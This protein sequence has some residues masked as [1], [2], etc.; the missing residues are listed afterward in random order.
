MY[1]LST[2]T[3]N[4]T[5]MEGGFRDIIA[6]Q[7]AHDFVLSVYSICEKFPSYERFGLWSQFTRAAVSI[8]AN[9]AEG[10]KK[11]SRA[12]KLRFLNISQSSLEECRYYIILSRDLQYI[13]KEDADLLNYKIDGASWYL[14]AYVNGIINNNGIKD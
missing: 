7:K 2:L 12:D 4:L 3:P 13:S 10:T 11:L 14:N 1:S 8:P 6:W 5:T 9:I